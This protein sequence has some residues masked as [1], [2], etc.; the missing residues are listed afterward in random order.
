[1]TTK[2]PIFESDT[3]DDD[4]ED[5]EKK[6]SLT[7]NPKLLRTGVAGYPND[8]SSCN[9]ENYQLNNTRNWQYVVLSRVKTMA[10]LY[11]NQRLKNDLDKYKKPE[12]MLRM[13]A[14][15]AASINYQSLTPI[16]YQ[17][18]TESTNF[19]NPLLRVAAVNVNTT[20]IAENDMVD[21]NY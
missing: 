15:F 9:A 12:E 8:R 16:E 1:M 20:T 10:G 11:L 5:D 19:Q 13:I 7:K 21:L 2:K 6:L 4:I 18:L 17:E 3:S 14:D